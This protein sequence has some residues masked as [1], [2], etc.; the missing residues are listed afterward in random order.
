MELTTEL[1]NEYLTLWQNCQINPA[2]ADGVA[3]Y[4]KQIEKYRNT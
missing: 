2:Y 4:V 3:W 1:K